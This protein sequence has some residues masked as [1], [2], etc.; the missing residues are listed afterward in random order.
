M[1]PAWG[2]GVGGIS[3]CPIPWGCSSPPFLRGDPTYL[4]LLPRPPSA[5]LLRD[6]FVPF[7]G[8]GLAGFGAGFTHRLSQ[9]GEEEWE[10]GRSVRHG[11]ASPAIPH[12]GAAEMSPARSWHWPGS[13]MRCRAVPPA[14]G[15]ATLQEQP[16]LGSPQAFGEQ[17]LGQPILQSPAPLLKEGR[18][19]PDLTRN[20]S[21]A[22]GTGE[23]GQGEWWH[24][25]PWVSPGGCQGPG[26]GL[27]VSQPCSPPHPRHCCTPAPA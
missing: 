9:Q 23:P 25:A 19:A 21:R 4:R 5:P 2:G 14:H 13:K 22:A 7:G 10:G 20:P 18:V 26:A 24:W 16:L 12:P 11:S 27:R 6:V 1:S 15:T 3:C 17:Q 8:Q